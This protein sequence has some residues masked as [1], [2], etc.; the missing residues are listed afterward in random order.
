[1][2]TFVHVDFRQRIKPPMC[3]FKKK[4]FLDPPRFKIEVRSKLIRYLIYFL[5]QPAF[6]FLHASKNRLF[7]KTRNVKTT[8]SFIVLFNV[9]YR[10]PWRKA[11]INCPFRR[12]YSFLWSICSTGCSCRVRSCTSNMKSRFPRRTRP[13]DKHFLGCLSL[14]TWKR[15][16]AKG[17]S[18]IHRLLVYENG[19]A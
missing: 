10:D 1:M 3:A 2:T 11:P 4:T 12:E 6:R 8:S 17:Q 5:R 14:A 18:T 19:Q 16:Q 9:S 15:I 13:V 7:G